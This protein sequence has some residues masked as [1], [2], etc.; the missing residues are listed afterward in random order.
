MTR[1]NRA[2]R[3]RV[4]VSSTA[5]C[6]NAASRRP[7]RTVSER[8]RSTATSPTRTT[9]P[10]ARC[11]GSA[12]SRP[13]SPTRRRWTSSRQ[14]SASTPVEMRTR[15]A[16]TTGTVMPTGQAMDGPAPVASCSSGSRRCRCRPTGDG[17]L[18]GLPGGVSNTT[19]GEGVR[20]GVGYAV[21]LQERRL[22]RRA[23]TTTRRRA[24]GSTVAG[25]EPLVE[26]HT[27]VCEVG[28]G[29]VTVQAQIA[30]TEL[31]VERVTVLPADT[32]VGQ[33]RLER[34]RRGRPGSR[35]AR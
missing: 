34:R 11:A 14:R 13:A 23:S 4:R 6:L 33:R 10:A 16:M 28:Q 8:R 27:A 3:R 32:Q 19:H 2:R 22:L 35:A 17:D 15:N 29:G 31:G 25:G 26:V 7:V 18:R 21:G 30:R 9:R 1:A 24:C 12:R 20:R 5:V